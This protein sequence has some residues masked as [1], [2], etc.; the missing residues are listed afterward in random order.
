[1]RLTYP[2]LQNAKPQSKPYKLRDRDSMYLRVSVSG[3]KV[4]KFDYRLDGKDCSYTLGRFPDLS[5]ADARQLRNAAAKLVAS[6]I[7]PKAYEKQLQ[8]Q[9]VAHQKNTLWPVCEEWLNDNRGNWTAYYHGQ[10]T[11]FLTRYVKNSQFGAMPIRDITVTH[12]YDLL[13]S[14]AKRKALAGDE[15]KAEGA[16]HIAI[17]LRQ[18]LDAVF[19][20]AIISGRVDSNPVAALKPSDVVT[21]PPTRHNRALGADELKNVLAAFSV[22]GTQL[23]RLAMRLLLLTSVRTVELRGATW[24]EFDL[25]SAIWAI[26]GGRMKMERAHVVPLSAQAIETLEKIKKISQPKSAD[27]YLF[28]NVRDKSRPMAAT[29]INAALVRAGFNHERLFR[30]HGARGTFSTWAH[31]QGFAPLAIERQLA[32]VERNRVSRAY[33]KAEFLPE[34]QKMMQAW[35]NYLENLSD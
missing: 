28:P 27:D 2:L 9:T 25:E 22:T 12:M 21:L 3:S 18:H 32:H 1:M 16:P 29:T 14:I 11:R 26:P 17:R 30:A 34:R 24:R 33:N 35:G 23:T 20:R 7:H 19:R 15:R 5:I 4:W 13:Q 6:G 8:Q 10:A 31:E